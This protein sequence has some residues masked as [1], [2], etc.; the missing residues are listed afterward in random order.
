MPRGPFI[1]E[2]ANVGFDDAAQ[3]L[4]SEDGL[5]C[6]D[7]RGAP[8]QIARYSIIAA[9]PVSQFSMAGG[10]ITVDGHTTIDS[11]HQALLRFCSKV[12]RWGADPYVPFNCGIIGYIGFE[13]ARALRGL[14]PADGFS[15]HPQCKLGLYDTAIVFD[16]M[17]RTAWVIANGDDP[18]QARRRAYILHDKVTSGAGA[19]HSEAEP[20][21]IAGVRM[22]P[23][24]AE[25][26]RTVET[27][28][29]WI[30]SDIVKR[31][32]VV[33][34]AATPF[35]GR[36]PITEFLSTKFEGVRSL[37]GHEGAYFSFSS[38]DS[39][40]DVE[41]TRLR[42]T[43]TLAP[44]AGRVN[45]GTLKDLRDEVAASIASICE[46][47]SVTTHGNA[48]AG[49]S[50]T[51]TLGRALSPMDAVVGMIPS[52]TTT[53]TPYGRVLKFIGQN[54]DTHRAF[55][56][57]A[58]GTIDPLR[59]SFRTIERASTYADGTVGTTAGMDMDE[60]SDADEIT[61]SLSRTLSGL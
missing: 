57:G 9:H 56:G 1:L 16:H 20:V 54:E 2:L 10:F 51:G 6:I 43:L 31:I 33:R 55:Y 3:A 12:S 58:F 35:E 61:G 46:K 30:R 22:T 52:H 53:G 18:P 28:R 14:A 37:I 42:S 13:A 44:A 59:C 23:S 60:N 41:G 39:L 19:V 48:G 45:E 50:V 38:T 27:A 26:R 21:R 40:V 47:G 17:E 15:R 5:V 4:S 34:H 36:S 11:P 24:E 49:L 29:S 32:H 8:P 7:A 25:F